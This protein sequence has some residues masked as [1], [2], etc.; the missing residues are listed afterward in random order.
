MEPPGAD[1]AALPPGFDDPMALPPP[2]ADA[3]GMDPMGLPPMEDP[4]MG[5]PP[6]SM[7]PGAFDPGLPPL[8]GMGSGDLVGLPPMDQ[9]FG[10]AQPPAFLEPGDAQP[11]AGTSPRAGELGLPAVPTGVKGGFVQDLPTFAGS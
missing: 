7:E 10:G 9:G 11:A 6:L 3:S 8:D 5:L 2:M 4:G 1:L